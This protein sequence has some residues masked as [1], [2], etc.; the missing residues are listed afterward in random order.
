[1]TTTR[2]IGSF[3]RDQVVQAGPTG[4]SPADLFKTLR[5]TSNVRYRGGSYA[6]FYRQF[7]WLIQAGYVVRI[8]RTEPSYQRGVA[9]SGVLA[10]KQFY[11]L[12]RRG[13]QVASER[14]E[15]PEGLIHKE[16][17]SPDWWRKYYTPTGRPRGRPRGV[18]RRLRRPSVVSIEAPTPE[19]VA[20]TLE[21][22]PAPPEERRRVR[23][24]PSESIIRRI[25][26]LQP[27][28]LAFSTDP[29][30]V[31]AKVLEDALLK[32][33]EQA[34]NMLARTTGDERE[35]VRALAEA[36]V[37]A[38]TGFADM[39]EAASARN[40]AAFRKGLARVGK[41]FGV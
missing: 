40:A 5:T 34:D 24:S 22:A 7:Y 19:E 9:V 4:V 35:K 26:A 21:V 20:P 18:A 36:L 6:S 15:N 27:D 41:L 16:R 3:I 8:D 14:W 28:Y 33:W 38:S 11:A 17:L 31:R 37:D 2:S 25:E 13:R 30:R 12:T 39:Y 23:I 10:P 29:T 32:V 1:M